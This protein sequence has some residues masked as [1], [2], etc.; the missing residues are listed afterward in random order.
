MKFQ[1]IRIVILVV[2][3][4]AAI[5]LYILSPV[6]TSASPTIFEVTAGQGVRTIAGNLGGD[7]L[8][9][10]RFAFE[11]FAAVRGEAGSFQP[12]MYRLNPT[13]SL[14]TIANELTHPADGEVQVTIP[15]GFTM[16]QIDAALANALVIRPGE[17]VAYAEQNGLEGKLFPDT[18]RFFIDESVADVA[19]TFLDDF[20][21]KAAPLFAGESSSTMQE[22][23]IL[24]SIVQ[25]EVPSETDERI[26]AGILQKRLSASIGLDVDATICYAK[27]LATPSTT[28]NCATLTSADFKI[29]SAYN[30]YLYRG[31]P[32]G[33][34]SNPGVAAIQAVL[35]PQSSPYL[36]YLTDPTNGQT[37]YAATLAEQEANQKKYLQ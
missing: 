2:V 5:F 14:P 20:N 34:I 23:L 30:T 17:L 21:A 27:Q 9:R 29:D 28:V 7:G 19:Q 37:I 11:A 15:E 25:K 31:L 13:M 1:I 3:I 6:N 33:P 36:Y 16:F 35:N 12:G 22:N 4:L 8:I 18:Y 24:A 10:S 26:V 32:P